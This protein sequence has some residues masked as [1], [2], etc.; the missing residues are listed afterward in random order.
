ML[1]ARWRAKSRKS[2]LFCGVVVLMAG[3][4]AKALPV[5]EE[6]LPSP[7][8]ADASAV[9][10]RPER[11]TLLT[12]GAREQLVTDR[13]LAFL[14]AQQVATA[15]L[16]YAQALRTGMTWEVVL[17]E[18]PERTGFAGYKYRVSLAEP[19]LVVSSWKVLEQ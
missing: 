12:P 1:E 2:C 9:S 19:D 3:C 17:I 4:R 5:K 8:A 18:A 10:D 6:S 16:T 13:A 14:M 15:G 11:L 7:P